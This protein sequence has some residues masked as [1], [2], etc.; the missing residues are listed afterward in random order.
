MSAATTTGSTA[1]QGHIHVGMRTRVKALM[2]SKKAFPNS[3]LLWLKDMAS[4]LNVHFEEVRDPH[5]CCYQG[6]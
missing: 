6:R 3:P 1:V 4:Y 5:R 2:L